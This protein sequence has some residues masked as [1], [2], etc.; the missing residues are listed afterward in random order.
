MNFTNVASK[1]AFEWKIKI[2][3]L[4]SS[5]PA[6]PTV[7]K[8]K[9]LV[10]ILSFFLKLKKVFRIKLLVIPAE[11]EIIFAITTSAFSLL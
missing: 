6:I 1:P 3:K 10:P 8:E 9:N 5:N 11:T 2:I 4:L 7:K